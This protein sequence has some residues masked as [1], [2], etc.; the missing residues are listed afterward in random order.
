MIKRLSLFTAKPSFRIVHCSLLIAI[1]ACG[2]ENPADPAATL[3]AAVRQTVAAQQTA[4]ATPSPSPA[5][6]NT[7]EPSPTEAPPISVTLQFPTDTPSPTSNS[8]LPTS[9]PTSTPMSVVTAGPLTRP[10]GAPVH[11]ARLPVA[12]TIDGDPSEWGVLA[13]TVDQVVFKPTNW[14]GPSDN[15][16]TFALGWDAANLYLAASV[17]DDHH[18]QTQRNEFIY[19]GDSIEILLDA[20]LGGDYTDFNLSD[21]DFQL[22]LSPGNLATG[23]P[24]PQAWLWF[25][26][27]KSGVPSG[28]TV[29][30][31][32]SGEGFT[33]EAAIPWAVFGVAPEGDVRYGFILSV[34]DN[35]NGN[36]A[37]QE[38]LISSAST[39]KLANPTTWG[40]LI[41]DP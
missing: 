8:Q 6:T 9:N 14:S 19:K 37:D 3:D 27:S 17:V 30:A 1:A 29:A 34:S 25:P 20:N 24:A 5:P 32:R 11:V 31:K 38:S 40:T 36:A 15:S 23:D 12:P 21:D 39:R 33:M 4:G 22:G 13:N 41:L 18:Q 10:N 7:P 35:D 26:A 2:G 16:A 28:I